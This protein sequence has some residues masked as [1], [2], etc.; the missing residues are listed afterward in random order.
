VVHVTTKLAVAERFTCKVLDQHRSTLRKAKSTAGD[1]AALTTD[2]TDLAT[3]HG[4]YGYAGLQP[5]CER[6]AGPAITSGWS[7]S[8]GAR[9]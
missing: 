3:R 9:G 2:I 6:R 1:E 5:C 7:G 4:R 8:G